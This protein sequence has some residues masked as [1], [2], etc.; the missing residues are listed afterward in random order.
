MKTD[1]FEDLYWYNDKINT[2]FDD[3]IHLT[4]SAC[5]M[6]HQLQLKIPQSFIIIGKFDCGFYISSVLPQMV[7]ALSGP[8][9]QC[10]VT[11]VL[12]RVPLCHRWPPTAIHVYILPGSIS[13]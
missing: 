3:Y 13:F 7:R 12:R 10:K 6:H 11:T 2:V 4:V 5:R 8:A 1:H 9:G